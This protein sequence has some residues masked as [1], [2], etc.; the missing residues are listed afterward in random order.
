MSGTEWD[1]LLVDTLQYIAN[2]FADAAAK[3]VLDPVLGTPYDPPLTDGQIK[4][5]AEKFGKLVSDANRAL[6]MND[7]D[8]A[9]AWRTILGSNDRTKPDPVLPLPPKPN[10]G[11]GGVE[12][13]GSPGQMRQHGS[14]RRYARRIIRQRLAGRLLGRLAQ[15]RV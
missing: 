13:P 4:Q 15:S 2:H 1:V 9:A 10:S 3:P 12:E 8:S 6:T 7:Y 5:A 14:G 11:N